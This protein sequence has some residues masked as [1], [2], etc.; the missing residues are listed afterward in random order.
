MKLDINPKELAYFME[1]T[2][3]NWFVSIL[4]AT[5][6]VCPKEAVSII[7]LVKSRQTS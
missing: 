3:G 5:Y 1:L 7:S 6:N 2:V 4:A